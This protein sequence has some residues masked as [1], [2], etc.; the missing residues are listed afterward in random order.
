MTEYRFESKE[1]L[2]ERVVL[3]VHV[4]I[5]HTQERIWV[6]PDYA[7][8]R[9]LRGVEAGVFLAETR[10]LGAFWTEFGKTSADG[11]TQA[12]WALCGAL[13][14]RR[15]A[16]WL[17]QEQKAGELLFQQVAAGNA[18]ALFTAVQIWEMYLRCRRGRNRRK[19]AA[20]LR[21]YAGLL[22]LP[23]GEYSPEMVNW[24]NKKPV[25]PVRNDSSD[26]RLEIWYPQGEV[27][28][29]CAVVSHALRPILIYYRQR[30]RDAG[31]LMRTCT[32]CGRVFFAASARSTLC[33]TR[34]RMASRKKA[35]R[36][37]EEKTKGQSY[38]QA[39]EREYMF[40]YNRITRLKR[41]NAPPE[42]I[43]AA[44]EAL[45]QFRQEA[46]KNKEQVKAGQMSER[47]FASWLLGQE[48]VIEEIASV[49]DK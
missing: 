44:Q 6:G 7:V 46:V 23:F 47:A 17:A 25:Q 32:N 39:Y 4:D 38:E 20:A 41:Q 26:A 30:I 16:E 18:A 45:K 27:S 12:V 9:A 37:F 31:L 5:K 48:A 15:S 36:A 11:W 14:A 33:G 35:R 21:A 8:Q 43:R 10:P 34:C 22:I 42:Q 3:A 13:T 40:W 24:Q 2:T 29:E 1:P 28:F 49:R 19:A